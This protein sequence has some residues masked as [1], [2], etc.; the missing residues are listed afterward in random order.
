MRRCVGTGIRGSLRNCFLE[1]QI[2]PPVHG[3]V[4][5]SVETVDLK[6][7]FCEFKS[8]L[9]YQYFLEEVYSLRVAK[10]YGV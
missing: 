7:M 10:R 4:V 2:L 8:H 6:S 1:V 5:K 9:P 3:E